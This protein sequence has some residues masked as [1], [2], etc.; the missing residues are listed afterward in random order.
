LSREHIRTTKTKKFPVESLTT[1]DKLIMDACNYAKALGYEVVRYNLGRRKGPDAVFRNHQN[2][3]VIL[4]IV[5]GS[6]FKKLFEKTRVKETLIKLDKYT[7]S[8][9]DFLGFIIVGDRIDNI[10]KHALTTGY[11][12]EFFETNKQKIF[13]VCIYD[14]KEIIPALLVSL[15]GS[16]ANTE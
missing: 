7:V 13:P 12:K 3:E 1:H 2:Q 8:K 10:E 5:T 15:L 14:F 4:E 16:R 11:S 6:T 9:Q